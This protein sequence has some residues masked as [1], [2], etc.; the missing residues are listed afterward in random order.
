[1]AFQ[2]FDGA[3]RKNQHAVLRLAAQDLLPGE[4]DDIELV[5]GKSLR[6]GG[7]GRVANRQ[8]D[9]VSAYPVAIGNAHARRGAVPGEHDVT[10]EIDLREIRQLA[11]GSL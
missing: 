11:V 7:A 9:A 10:A 2:A 6:E 1:V 3:R 5:E 4:S 8:A